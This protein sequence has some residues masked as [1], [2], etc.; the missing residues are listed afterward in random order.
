MKREKT[1]DLLKRIHEEFDIIPGIHNYC[2]R[3]CERCRFCTQCSVYLME[4]EEE[5]F[6]V[7][8]DLPESDFAESM[9]NIFQDT[10]EMVMDMAAEN[11]IDLDAE[12]EMEEEF[13]P[14]RR[15]GKEHY[16]FRKADEH[17]KWLMQW[18][19]KNNKIINATLEKLRESS[20]K[21]FLLFG[22]SIETLR[23][24][25]HFIAVKFAR[26]L[27]PPYNDTPE[28]GYDKN[29]SAKIAIIAIENTL[30]AMPAIMKYFPDDEDEFLT[31]MVRLERLRK[32]ALKEFPDA[33]SFKRPGFDD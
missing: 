23:W 26:A 14:R 27:M 22:N 2:D 7:E 21:D 28:A 29:G 24:Y 3:W 6:R 18:F 15:P 31:A 32:R 33:M 12:V 19:G 9:S 30:K 4:A 1:S 17:S 25:M 13:I 20:K 10:L 11:G 8:N 5:R 16:L